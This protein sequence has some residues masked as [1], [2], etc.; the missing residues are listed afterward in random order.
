MA[1]TLGG[2]FNF[3]ANELADSRFIITASSDRF[4]FEQARMGIGLTTFASE[5]TQYF[6]L[7]DSESYTTDAGWRAI[8]LSDYNNTSSFTFI[9]LTSSIISA[10]DFYGGDFDGGSGSFTAV[11]IPLWGDLSES[12]ASIKAA[13]G[14]QDLQSVTDL[15]DSTTTKI[16]ASSFVASSST[17]D[18]L[19]PFL[20]L[21]HHVVA[22]E[23]GESGG[24][25]S[26]RKSTNATTNYGDFATILLEYTRKVGLEGGSAS[27]P[28]GSAALV[29]R[30]APTDGGFRSVTGPYI[31]PLIL[32]GSTTDPKAVFPSAD[33]TVDGGGYEARVYSRGV[34][35]S[36]GSGS[37]N[38]GY[39]S[40]YSASNTMKF[41][42]GSAG[43][44][45]DFNNNIIR[46]DNSYISGSS[47]GTSVLKFHSGIYEFKHSS[48]TTVNVYGTV[49]ASNLQSGEGEITNLDTTILT[50]SN[51]V[52]SHITA[53][54]NII[55]GGGA[56]SDP[57]ITNGSGDFL[58][59]LGDG[60]DLDTQ[61][62]TP[63][64]YAGAIMYSASNGEGAFY[65]GV[66]F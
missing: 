25:I 5:S 3:T 38:P 59:V 16:T 13:A 33:F 21:Q 32:S 63:T 62:T 8:P 2:G 58:R 30:V 36:G 54:G 6:I 11:E 50:S 15:G 20:S 43:Y 35:I 10:S 66:E 39:I 48:A 42:S 56:S 1:T 31:T 51:I 28:T 61:T 29:F 65:L 19:K 34:V 53:S 12:L 4:T 60:I 41:G 44:T 57:G 52:T 40:P 26:F 55:L 17:G 37:A 23:P 47:T 14:A 24:Q 46:F 27:Q 9:S 49:S 64:A 22:P 45:L 18:T 7:A